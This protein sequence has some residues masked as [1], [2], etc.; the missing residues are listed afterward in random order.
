ML[1]QVSFYSDSNQ[2]AGLSHPNYLRS[3][4][5]LAEGS[6]STATQTMMLDNKR[7]PERSG[8][9]RFRWHHAPSKGECG[10]A[11]KLVPPD[12]DA[13]KSFAASVSNGDS[14]NDNNKSSTSTSK[15]KKKSPKHPHA[16][17]TYGDLDMA[18]KNEPHSEEYLAIL[19]RREESRKARE[20][21]RA[22]ELEALPPITDDESA[23]MRRKFLEDQER[24]D[25]ALK[26]RE[27]D[28]DNVE[29]LRKYK[30]QIQ[31]RQERVHE[32]IVGSAQKQKD[33]TCTSSRNDKEATD[34]NVA[35]ANSTRKTTVE[36]KS[37]QKIPC[38]FPKTCENALQ[39]SPKPKGKN[40][41]SIK[42]RR[43]QQQLASDIELLERK[44]EEQDNKR[45]A[46]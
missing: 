17:D 46:S 15:R 1:Q 29:K 19:A 43:A 23:A 27:M 13:E 3:S 20:T 45:L 6:K 33:A 5:W 31:R 36:G 39:R 34:A 25:Y 9:Y 18:V 38:T 4:S 30:S 24:K 8:T 2:A 32:R 37:E 22:R 26:E 44:F 40:T 7:D 41:A 42:N 12:F 16:S 35:D 28:E 11:Y 21:E 10:P 14:D